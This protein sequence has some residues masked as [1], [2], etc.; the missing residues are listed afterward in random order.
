MVMSTQLTNSVRCFS[1]DPEKRSYS[2]FAPPSAQIRYLVWLHILLNVSKS[3]RG[4]LR[5]IRSTVEGFEVSLSALRNALG[6]YSMCRKDTNVFSLLDHYYIVNSLTAKMKPKYPMVRRREV[7]FE[8]AW[9]WLKEWRESVSPYRL[10]EHLREWNASIP[11]QYYFS[12]W[13][14]IWGWIPLFEW[15][16]LDVREVS[17][18]SKVPQKRRV[19][20]TPDPST[21][22]PLVL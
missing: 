14:H 9:F 13:L 20:Q 15:P 17:P 6:E 5:I 10:G 8:R 21:T 22:A 18:A 1:I 2:L 4:W 16:Y 11:E 12:Q 7:C 19:P 3:W